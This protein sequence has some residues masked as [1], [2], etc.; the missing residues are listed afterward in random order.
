MYF[1]F[2]DL[3]PC[4]FNLADAADLLYVYVWSCVCVS[5]CA[6]GCLVK[7]MMTVPGESPLQDCCVY[8]SKRVCVCVRA[9]ESRV[10]L[11]TELLT[12]PFPVSSVSRIRET[13]FSSQRNDT[14]DAPVELHFLLFRNYYYYCYYFS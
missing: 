13:M 6:R 7:V 5:N 11:P 14:Y 3:H 9:R 12:S 10:K 4:D 8:V 1:F 2:V